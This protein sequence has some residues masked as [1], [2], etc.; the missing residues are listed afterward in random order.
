MEFLQIGRW[1]RGAQAA[2]AA[3]RAPGQ[4]V[5]RV[6]TVR[7]SLIVANCLRPWPP[8]RGFRSGTHP[9]PARDSRRLFRSAR[10][11]VAQDGCEFH[12][13]KTYAALRRQIEEVP[14][15]KLD[16]HA[17]RWRNSS[18]SLLPHSQTPPGAQSALVPAGTRCK[19]APKKALCLN[20]DQSCARSA[21][22]P[23]QRRGVSRCSTDIDPRHAPANGDEDD[24]TVVRM[25]PLQAS[26]ERS[27][28]EQGGQLSWLGS[29][30]DALASDRPIRWRP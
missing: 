1:V 12:R 16:G 8:W 2:L 6:S 22:I 11:R 3:K 25:A 5:P 30:S 18:V 23:I 29:G 26:P 13:P 15:R 4:D 19:R 27:G 9:R 20:F 21:Q 17:R 10:V 28:F 14:W 24:L 7:R